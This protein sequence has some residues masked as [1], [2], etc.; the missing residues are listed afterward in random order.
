M[1]SAG[2]LPL[3]AIQAACTTGILMKRGAHLVALALAARATA[4]YNRVND[5][6]QYATRYAPEILTNVQIRRNIPGNY[7]C[8]KADIDCDTCP[9]PGLLSA[10][11][12]PV[13]CLASAGDDGRRRLMVRH[14]SREPPRP[15][16]SAF[17]SNMQSTMGGYF[18]PL[19][20]EAASPKRRCVCSMK[21]KI[22]EWL[23]DDESD[24][25]DCQPDNKNMGVCMATGLQ[26][27]YGQQKPDFC[28]AVLWAGFGS[29]LLTSYW[30]AQH[31]HETPP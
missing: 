30:C 27:Y 19:E 22:A 18:G 8:S 14:P 6:V 28:P 3:G 25:Y 5:A 4:Q 31:P 9:E 12:D 11:K 24:K 2:V 17:P 16:R 7:F 23:D 20:G 15:S 13:W 10:P 26:A 21:S 29:G 1:E